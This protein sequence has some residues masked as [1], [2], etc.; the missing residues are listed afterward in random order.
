[1][2]K[3]KNN[4]KQGIKKADKNLSLAEKANLASKIIDQL[5]YSS[6]PFYKAAYNAL[7]KVKD[8]LNKDRFLNLV[9]KF[10]EIQNQLSELSRN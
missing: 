7:K 8:E 3:V 2:T 5:K 6:Q 1:M 9:I 10:G 4:K